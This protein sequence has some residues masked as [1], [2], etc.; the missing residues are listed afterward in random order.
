MKKIISILVILSVFLS[1]FCVK[2]EE[3]II[4]SSSFENG[5]EKWED[6]GKY[7]PEYVTF[8]KGVYT[9]GETSI[10][11]NDIKDSASV[12][13]ISPVFLVKEGETYSASVD[14]L[15]I[16]GTLKM[17]FAYYDKNDKQLLNKSASAKA[18]EWKNIVTTQKAPEGAAYAQIMLSSDSKTFG[19]GYFDNFYFAKGTLVPR[20]IE[21][22]AYPE[23]KKAQSSEFQKTE[24][25]Y[26]EDF[27]N[28]L[29]SY[30]L[31]SSASEK[32]VSH[33][34]TETYE[35]NG[36]IRID[37]DSDTYT[38]GIKSPFYEVEEG[39]KYTASFYIKNLS[40][41][42]VKLYFKFFDE[43]K[44]QILAK[45]IGPKGNEWYPLSLTLEA[46]EGAKYAQIQ[47]VGIVKDIGVAVVDKAQFHKGTYTPAKTQLTYTP[48]IQKIAVPA[49][50]IAPEGDK[51]VYKSYNEKGDKLT[52][53][54][55]AG[56]FAGDYL[57]PESES[58]S[59]VETI[60]PTGTK[61]DTAHIQAAID[62]H[63]RKDGKMGI[64]KLKAGRYYIN[65]EGIKI[66]SGVLLSGEGQ[67]P[68]G[69]V[70]YPFADKQY[71][72]VRIEGKQY[73]ELLSTALI[74]DEYVK[75]GSDKIHIDESRIN[76][77]KVGDRIVIKHTS[78]DEWA[79]AIKM[80]GTINVYDDVTTW[81]AGSVQMNAERRIKAINGNEIT[82]D[83]GLFV[84]Y[85]KEL[86]PSYIVKILDNEKVENAG[87]ENL[88]LESYFNG[89]KNDEAH[90]VS[91]ISVS[92]AKNIIIRDVT[93]KYFY[94]G[95][96]KMAN[97]AK[98]VTVQNCSCLEPVSKVAG[99]RRYSF[100]A[101]TGS[102]QIL[103]TGCYSYDA[104]HDYA[105]SGQAS[106]PVVFSDSVAE[107]ANTSSET[108]GTWSTGILYDNIY[109][110]GNSS[111]GFTAIANRGIYGTVR[112]QG[113]TGAGCVVWNGLSS[114]QILHKPPLTYENFAV[115][116][117]GLY[118]DDDGMAQ[119]ERNI[120]SFEKIYRTG[121]S[122]EHT[123]ENF[124]TD[125][126][127]SIVGD[128]YK[129][130]IYTPVEPRSLFKAQLAQRYTGSFKNAK[131]N[132][133]ILIN[134]FPDGFFDKN[135]LTF[136]GIYQMG[137]DKVTL[138][139]DDIPYE[140]KLN[141]A[142]NT[143]SLTL[144]LK[145]G[146]HKLYA[147]QTI[148]NLESCKTADRFFSINKPWENGAHLQSIYKND[149]TGLLLNDSRVT[150]DR[151]SNG[152]R[153]LVD[154]YLLVTDVLPFNDG[155]RV[156]V[157]L[158]SIFESLGA[159]LLWDD[160][161]KTATAIRGVNEIKIT[162]N[163]TT[164]YKNGEAVM[165]DIPAKIID[166]RFVVPVRFISEAL[167]CKVE[168]KDSTQTV[169]IALQSNASI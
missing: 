10:R 41:N 60:S 169:I 152:I 102:Q 124:A 90:A 4:F 122:T 89:D 69:T 143:F 153:V 31:Y 112:S 142:D 106:G 164:A 65:T 158:R 118:A 7:S 121:E 150:Y 151:V 26:S 140:A 108:H 54:S 98:N 86:V 85:M 50:I 43:N 133:P 18:G 12:G 91:A 33:Y 131:P 144:T 34:T 156:L 17:F 67:G 23:I 38:A 141:E 61:D 1:F 56:F 72:A 165:L 80:V 66:K 127:T 95:L 37:D 20:E 84:P 78:T 103:V 40:G 28:G 62:R 6:R 75:A 24:L 139:I 44:K 138:Y 9:D 148:D 81:T 42:S 116:I 134:P 167:G 94:F 161:T 137:A 154:D 132:A 92:Y 76:H 27:E 135:E 68:G 126:N 111:K 74:S 88:R 8:K 58:L 157:P 87:V 2:A 13:L 39:M 166:G 71:T 48:P 115:G 57:P 96:A 49:N 125:E 11:V 73:T 129:E 79:K 149:K 15:V 22:A 159:A 162:L 59:I 168:W 145:D 128:S 46:V 77:F 64:L 109:H 21:N 123:E 53:F 117:W 29:G 63:E 136:E 47:I 130:N 100:V 16:S 120:T 146:T 5:R 147:T 35:G 110:I 97:G 51:L 36:A 55:Y 101:S 83:F 30:T 93:S 99:E 82:L 163:S 32:L 160:A 114:T 19:D 119:K 14:I 107:M 105:T 52:D 45:S 104:R 3:E 155:G 25:L 113:W 70:L